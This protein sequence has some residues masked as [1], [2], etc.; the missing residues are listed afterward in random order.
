[1]KKIARNVVYTWHMHAISNFIYLSIDTTAI[2]QMESTSLVKRKQ[3]SKIKKM[4]L[5]YCAHVI[6]ACKLNLWKVTKLTKQYIEVN[7]IRIILDRIVSLSFRA[8]SFPMGWFLDYIDVS[9]Y[10]VRCAS[11]PPS[12]YLY[13]SLPLKRVQSTYF[14]LNK[15][16]V[17]IEQN[18]H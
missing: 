9:V 1:M 2:V 5:L 8:I 3:F 7:R 16:L 6:W 4:Y 14:P 18:V 10:C 17:F 12:S 11:P 13:I 15:L